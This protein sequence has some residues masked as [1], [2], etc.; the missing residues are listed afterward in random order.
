MCAGKDVLVLKGW[1]YEIEGTAY[2][3]VN[4]AEWQKQSGLIYLGPRGLAKL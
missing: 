1:A 2:R 4:M 3:T